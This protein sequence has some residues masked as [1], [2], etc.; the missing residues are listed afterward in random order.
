MTMRTKKP[1]AWLCLLALT[2]LLLAGCSGAAE[3]TASDQAAEPADTQTA[4]A[5]SPDGP[6]LPGLSYMRAMEKR[7]AEQFDV[8]YYEGGYK[9]LVI[10][11]GNRYLVVPEGQSAPAG[12]DPEIKLLYQPLD[13]IYLAGSSTMALFDAMDALDA[14]RL[15]SIERSAWYVESA[16]DAMARGDI[17]FGGKY[18]EPDYELLEIEEITLAIENTMILHSPKVIEMI[19][20]LGVPVFI[21]YSSYEPHPLG[22]TEWV[23][24][25]GALIDREEDAEAFFERKVAVMDEIE[26]FENTGKT[27]AIF[28]IDTAG[29]A[30]VRS[31]S[32]YLAQI[33]GIAGGVNAFDGG[34]SNQTNVGMTMEEFYASAVDIDYLIYNASGYSSGVNSLEK[35]FEMSD[36][37]AD[38]KAVKNGDIWWIGPETYQHSDQISDLIADV[39]HMLTGQEAE[40]TFLHH[41]E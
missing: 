30:Q 5:A 41:M 31:G 9:Y 19:E 23:K 2:I 28:L 18:S 3:T 29:K 22:R 40:M 25:F 24:L 14:V 1:V 17:L 37:L 34:G 4:A 27:V 20:L 6:E 36:L 26:A 38:C 8:Y 7:Y 32:D 15:S 16:A 33:I 13:R 39:H 12:L 10:G 21:D 35:L 11:D